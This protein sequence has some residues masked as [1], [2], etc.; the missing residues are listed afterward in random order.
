MSS[1]YEKRIEAMLRM[2]HEEKRKAK[3]GDAD[4]PLISRLSDGD[5]YQLNLCSSRKV[6]AL[7]ELGE[8]DVALLEEIEQQKQSHYQQLVWKIT[9]AMNPIN[10]LKGYNYLLKTHKE[11]RTNFIRGKLSVDVKVTYEHALMNFP[12]TD[13]TELDEKA[14]ISKIVNV[15]AAEARRIYNP[16]NSPVLRMQLFKLRKSEYAVVVSYIAKLCPTINRSALMKCMFYEMKIMLDQGENFDKRAGGM[17]EALR[18]ENLAYWKKELAEATSELTIPGEN[19]NVYGRYV[20]EKHLKQSTY[21]MID[22]ELW[23]KTN[24]YCAQNGVDKKVLLL[25]VWAEVLGSY[26][27][28]KHPS[29]LVVGE[30]EEL[31][32]FPIT[33]S[34]SESKESALRLIARKWGLASVHGYL[35]P[36]DFQQLFDATVLKRFHM[37]H[38]FFDLQKPDQ[39]SKLSFVS[40]NSGCTEIGLTINY[41]IFVM[42]AA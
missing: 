18:T 30:K 26:H 39:N 9:G 11:L 34:R 5:F 7:E 38:C 12:I 1:E 29:L 27:G 31:A 32:Y 36:E 25:Y 15:S 2:R 40:G 14:Q 3:L 22:A 20:R 8:K 19:L 24:D 4:T 37:Q 17:N 28:E 16:E 6:E 33:V 42:S 35:E 21:K 41:H 13:I 23:K 10:M